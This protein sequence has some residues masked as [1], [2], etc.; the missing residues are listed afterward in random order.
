MK[1]ILIVDD[2]WAIREALV[3]LLK[4]DTVSVSCAKNS[5]EALEMIK[6]EDF[7]L[8][9]LDINLGR[10]N[11]LDLLSEIRKKRCDQKV[12]VFTGSLHTE[13]PDEILSQSHVEGIVSK[14]LDINWLRRKIEQVLS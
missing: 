5:T 8:I 4:E 3:E 11:G 9:L 2:E 6:T 7:D 10:L 12:I 13:L 14:P 1:R